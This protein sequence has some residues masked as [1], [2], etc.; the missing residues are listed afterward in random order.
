MSIQT[1]SGQSIDQRA[2]TKPVADEIDVFGLTHPGR[3]RSTNADHFLIA[4]FRRA[5]HVH[6]SSLPVEAFP[7]QSTDTRGFLFVVADGVGA[8]PNAMEGSAQV[9]DAVARYLVEM[10]EVSMQSDPSR[11]DEVA[12][13]LREV[14]QH[15]HDRLVDFGAQDPSGTAATTLTML[16]VM[17]PRAFLVH[18]GD[19]RCYRLRD[20]RLEKMSVDQTMAQVMVDSGA[21]SAEAVRGTR[22]EHVLVSALGGP[23]VS[24]QVGSFDVTRFDRLLLCSDGLTRHV[25]EAEIAEHLASDKGSRRVCEDLL[26]MALERGGDDNIT[27]LAGRAQA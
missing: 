16:T 5:M 27:I 6:A 14:V 1:V 11:S 19:S 25:S 7:S 3:R 26:A 15:A 2:M 17:F 24:L 20:G 23:Q 4:S 12:E 21:M 9:T 10:G 22:L 8:L 13:R 18:A